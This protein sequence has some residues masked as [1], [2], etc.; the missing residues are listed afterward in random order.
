MDYKLP[1]PYQTA[2]LTHALSRLPGV[3]CLSLLGDQGASSCQA[4]V[5]HRTDVLSSL[6]SPHVSY[7]SLDDSLLEALMRSTALQQL[8]LDC[9]PPYGRWEMD[10]WEAEGLRFSYPQPWPAVPLLSGQRVDEA[11]ARRANHE[12]RLAFRSRSHLNANEHNLRATSELA[13]I[14]AVSA[15]GS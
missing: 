14:A 3:T 9:T 6:T 8:R 5:T 11:T 7:I 13:G 10:D 12:L 4:P 2:C 1:R 15:L